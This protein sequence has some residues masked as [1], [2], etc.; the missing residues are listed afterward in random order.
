MFCFLI[1]S[2]RLGGIRAD[3]AEKL[4]RVGRGSRERTEGILGRGSSACQDPEA[5]DCIK[6]LMSK[7]GDG[8]LVSEA[9]F[10][11]GGHAASRWPQW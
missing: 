3:F 11:S 6:E 5:W 8:K 4:S 10:E 9:R 1:G 2:F 7:S